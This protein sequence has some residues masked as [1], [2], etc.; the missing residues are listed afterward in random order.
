MIRKSINN[1]PA[2]CTV[3]S[4]SCHRSSQT[5]STLCLSKKIVSLVI[6]YQD[7]AFLRLHMLCEYVS[8][9]LSVVHSS[10]RVCLGENGALSAHVYYTY[11]PFPR[12]VRP[13]AADLFWNTSSRH[14]IPR[15]TIPCEGAY[16]IDQRQPFTCHPDF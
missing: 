16:S 14:C 5:L 1:S 11:L 6:V 4:P 9:L 2:R 3:F 7:R 13:A 12:D 8:R 10:V 15:I